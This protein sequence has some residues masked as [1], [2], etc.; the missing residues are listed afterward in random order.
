MRAAGCSVTSTIDILAAFP[1]L[2]VTIQTSLWT[3]PVIQ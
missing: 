3:G 2:S 1:T